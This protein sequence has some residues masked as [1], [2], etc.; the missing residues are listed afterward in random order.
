[1]PTNSFP[2]LVLMYTQSISFFAARGL[3]SCYI[4]VTWRLPFPNIQMISF[5][6]MLERLPLGYAPITNRL[7]HVTF[8]SLHSRHSIGVRLNSVGATALRSGARSLR[9]GLELALASVAS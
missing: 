7:R 1:M 6:E 2:P 5:A 4:Q 8:T 9:V 3:P